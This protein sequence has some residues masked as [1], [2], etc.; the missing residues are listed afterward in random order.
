MEIRLMRSI[1][2]CL[3]LALITPGLVR[4]ETPTIGAMT[5]PDF[6]AYT[7]THT[8]TYDYGDGQT[9]TEEYMTGRRVRWA[10]D[11]DT[12][13]L[14]HWYDQADQIC[15]VYDQE[16]TPQCWNFFLEANGLR[17]RYLGPDGSFDI[18]EINQS[19]APLP[20]AGPDVGV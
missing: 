13:M 7:A 16:S 18:H 2:L 10:F 8:I 11:G 12:C 1:L 19:D 17:G 5:G 14:G 4:A 15:F 9:G 3:S 20:C 6:E